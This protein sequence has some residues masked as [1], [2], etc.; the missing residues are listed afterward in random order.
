MWNQTFLGDPTKVAESFHL[1]DVVLE[2]LHK[3]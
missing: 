2:S 3:E 1:L